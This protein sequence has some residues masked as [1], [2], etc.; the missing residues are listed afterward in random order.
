MSKLRKVKIQK[1]AFKK[2]KNVAENER[3]KGKKNTAKRGR[4]FTNT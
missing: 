4:A 1:K 3:L 2:D